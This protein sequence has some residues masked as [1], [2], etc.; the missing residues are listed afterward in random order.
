M[1]KEN[2][3][4]RACRRVRRS[5]L[6]LGRSALS[7]LLCLAMLLTTFCFFDIGSLVS[8]AK[9]ETAANENPSVYFYVPEAIYLAPKINS[10]TSANT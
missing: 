9:I 8:E 10:L 1:K 3:K 6:R 5:V 2:F 7:V 4:R